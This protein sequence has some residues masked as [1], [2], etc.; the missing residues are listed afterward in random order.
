[1]AGV[2]KP[3][4]TGTEMGKERGW[5]PTTRAQCDAVRGPTGPLLIALP[6]LRA[7]TFLTELRRSGIDVGRR[8]RE[9]GSGGT[10]QVEPQRITEVRGKPRSR[11][12]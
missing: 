2:S 8:G 10:V 7:E 12:A 11:Q 1:M 5:A 6:T 9:R 4:L 3:Y